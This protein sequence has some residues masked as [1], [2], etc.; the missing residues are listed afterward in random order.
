[1]S[2]LLLRLL[3][4]QPIQCVEHRNSNNLQSSRFQMRTN[5]ILLFVQHMLLIKS[6]ISCRY[7]IIIFIRCDGIYIFDIDEVDIT[8]TDSNFEAVAVREIMA[9]IMLTTSIELC[10]CAIREAAINEQTN[11]NCAYRYIE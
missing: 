11:E 7:H 5:R 4:A 8:A 1:M 9:M 3:N 10:I 2:Q 6:S